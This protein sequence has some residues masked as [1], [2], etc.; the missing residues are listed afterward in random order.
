M[1]HSEALPLLQRISGR[2]VGG[3]YDAARTFGGAP[4]ELRRHIERLFSGLSYSK[5]DPV[6]SVNDLVRASLGLVEANRTLLDLDREELVV[7]QT[8]TLRQPEDA[9]D[10]PTVDVAIYCVRLDFSPFARS[11]AD[12]VRI[13]TPSTYSEPRPGE[14]SDGK[15]GGAQ[16]FP[17][18]TDPAGYITECR[19]A[20]FMFVEGGRIKLPDR[21]NVLHGV[22]MHT[23]LKLAARLGVEVEEGLYSPAQVYAADEAFVSSTRYC[24]LPVS[25]VNGLEIGESIPGPITDALLATWK[26]LVG[27]DFVEKALRASG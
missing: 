27:D 17:L 8:V 9:D 1:P 6:I 14:S 3:Y 10:L 11:Y 5:I 24:M 20:N 2:S 15:G 13:F 19:G 16:I 12:G 4:F 21:R 23:V 18:M 7:T 22:S 26:D 25:A